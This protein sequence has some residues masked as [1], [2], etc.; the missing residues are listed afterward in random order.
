[1]R[2]GRRH[3]R[4]AVGGCRC[5]AIGPRPTGA[6]RWPTADAAA[7]GRRGQP[8]G[9]RPTGPTRRPTADGANPT[10]H[11]RRGTRHNLANPAPRG[12]R[13]SLSLSSRPKTTNSRRQVQVCEVMPP[14]GAPRR[15]R[16][17]R[18]RAIDESHIDRQARTVRETPAASP[19]HR[20]PRGALRPHQRA[21]SQAAHQPKRPQ[22]D[23][24]RPSRPNPA[25]ASGKTR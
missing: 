22:P 20:D 16:A 4:V 19:V 23:S 2:R 11:G 7:N 9:P 14:H 21:V 12:L 17:T 8:G 25:S 15:Q 24:P 1:M 3:W 6:T 18:T 13:A 5:A 10:A